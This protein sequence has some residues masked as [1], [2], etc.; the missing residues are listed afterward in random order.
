MIKIKNMIK[1]KVLFALL[2]S[3]SFI[4][5]CVNKD[6]FFELEDRGGIGPDL[7]STEGTIQLHLNRAYDVIMPPF[8]FQNPV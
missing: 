8:L 4:M 6:E 1:L 3:T 5:S 7:W 2:I